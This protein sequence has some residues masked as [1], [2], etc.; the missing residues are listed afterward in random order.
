MQSSPSFDIRVTLGFWKY[1][2]LIFVFN[3]IF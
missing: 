1:E 3:L 2:K